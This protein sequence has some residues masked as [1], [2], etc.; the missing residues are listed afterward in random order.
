V[1][2]RLLAIFP[3]LEKDGYR[4]KSRATWD[5]NCIAWA[6]S[7]ADQWW[8]PDPRLYGYWPPGVARQYTLQ[9]YRDAYVTLGYEPCNT[10]DFEIA[11]EKIVFFADAAG[12]PTHAARQL[13]SG[14]WTSKLGP[15]VDIEHATPD[16]L[17]G[18]DYGG[19]VLFMW[20]PRPLWRWPIVVLKRTGALLRDRLQ[21][22]LRGRRIAP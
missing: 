15:D 7:R 10:G 21:R 2:D 3:G 8:E 22:C 19:P 17:N 4:E 16:A 20:R 11:F 12:V 5:Y 1:A 14:K 6:A 18:P 9:A 13:E